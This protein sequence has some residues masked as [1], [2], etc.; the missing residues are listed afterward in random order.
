MYKVHFR[1]KEE[2]YQ[3]VAESL[4]LTHPYFVS[5]KD[6]ILDYEEGMVVNPHLE[7]TKKRFADISSIMIPLQN[8]LLIETLQPKAKP[9]PKSAPVNSNM[10][11]VV[12]PNQDEN[13][14]D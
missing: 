1:L 12:M 5:I 8:V 7:A 10:R 13:D 4:D 6:M 3:L 2:E 14:E 9:S 11:V